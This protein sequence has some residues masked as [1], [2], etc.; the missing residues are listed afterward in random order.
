MGRRAAVDLYYRFSL[1]PGATADD[2]VD[3]IDQVEF[4]TEANASIVSRTREEL[5]EKGTVLEVPIRLV[6][7]LGRNTS[8]REAKDGLINPFEAE[9][10]STPFQ[11]CELD[12]NEIVDEGYS[13]DSPDDDF[14][15]PPRGGLELV[16]DVDLESF[17]C[18]NCGHRFQYGLDDEL[19]KMICPECGFAGEVDHFG[20]EESGDDDDEY[21]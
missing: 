6:F 16:T 20:G 5:I 17:A 19:T 14:Q 21:D 8:A 10:P 12:G 4:E 13:A 2:L 15:E 1:C 7:D 9:P 3:F 11:D 18:P